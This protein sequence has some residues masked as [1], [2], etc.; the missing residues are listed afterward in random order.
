MSDKKLK[1]IS[2]MQESR[3]KTMKQKE[4]NIGTLLTTTKNNPTFAKLLIFTLN[5][6]EN[7]ISPPN[8]EIRVNA[9]VIIRL[10][11]VGIL[12]TTVI[13]N[14]SKDEIVSKAGGIIW[15]LISVYNNLD[16]E[17]AK[18]FAEKNGHKAVIEI[19][20]QRQKGPHEVTEP[21][22]KVL[23]GLVQIPQLVPSLLESGLVDTF[24][25]ESEENIEMI[26]LNLD[27]L[28][29]V[30][31]QKIGR[32][33]L[34][35]KNFVE[36]IIKNIKICTEKNSI[37]SVLC[38]LAVVDNLSRNED[39]KKAIKDSGGIDCLSEVLDAMGYDDYV[40]KMCAKIYG[41]IATLD[42]MQKQIILLKGYYET[43]KTGIFDNINLTDVKNCLVLI[44]NFML[45]DELGKQ[46]Q[47]LENFKLLEGTFEEIQKA[48]LEGKDINILKVYVLIN[49][50]FMQIFYRLFSL[51]INVYNKKTEAGKEEENLINTIQNSIKKTWEISK[52]LTEKDILEIFSTYFSSYGEIINQKYKIL[53][54]SQELDEEMSNILC[55]I[56]NNVIIDGQKNF[57]KEDIN[58]HKIA[59][60]ILKISDELSIHN[61][62]ETKKD[63]LVQSLSICL[64]YLENLFTES[65]NDEILCNSL[66]V[67]Y[68]LLNSNKEIFEKNIE[69][70]I[71]KICDFMNK[72]MEHRYPC[73]Q[74]MKLLDK[75]L[76][77]EFVTKYIKEKDPSK[78]PTHGID[79]VECIVNVLAY[80]ENINKDKKAERN[81]SSRVE[82]EIN[83]I[84]SKLMERL[85]Q[86]EE[87]LKK[88]IKE[89]CLSADSFEPNNI[90]NK[91]MVTNLEKLTKIMVGLMTVKKFYEEGANDILKSLTNLIQK[92]VKY[93][94]FYKIDKENKK[95][96]NYT[97]VLEESAQR[98]LFEL[99]LSLKI[100]DISQKELNFQIY[101][102]GLNI[103]F[104]FLSKSSNNNNI[105]Y[106]LNYFSKNSEFIL[107]EEARILSETKESIPEKETSTFTSLLRK[108]I[109][110]EEVIGN[111]INNL[112]LLGEKKQELCNTMVKGGCPRLLLQI[113]ETSPYEENVEK[114]LNLLKIIA[115]CNLNNLTMVANQNAMIKFFEAKNKYHS[116][117]T[118]INNCDEIS[119]EILKQVPGQDV[120]ADELIKDA[121]VGFNENI[122]NDFTLAEIKQKLLNNLEIINSFSTNKTQ[123]ENLNK[124]T[125]FIS[126][127]KDA[128]NKIFGE[129]KMTQIIEKLFSNLLSL[130]KKLNSLDAFDHE[131]TTG[132]LIE[133]IKNKSNL[134]DILLSATEEIS[135][136]LMDE[137][138]YSKL[139]KGK[140]DN[141]F[142]DAIFEDIDDYL[143]D[144]NVSKELNNILCYLCLRDEQM[145][146]Y[147][148]EKGGLTNVLEEL[149][150]NIDSNDKNSKQMKINAIKM[151][152]SLCNDKE[153]KESLIKA[154]GLELLSKILENEAESYEDYK[155]N[156]YK[157]LFKT[158]NILKISEKETKE[159]ETPTDN[160]ILYCV[161]LIKNIIE[162]DNKDFG[163]AKNIKNLLTISEGEYPKKDVFIE[164]CKIY[165]SNEHLDLP[166]EDNYIFL[167]L[168]Q[169]LSF[170]A[171]LGNNKDINA[172]DK[173]AEKI[174]S[175][176]KEN[177][178]FYDKIKIS[179]KENKN[180]TL[181]LTYLGN[182]VTLNNTF[183]E[184]GKNFIDEINAF[185]N[186]LLNLYKEKSTKE[187]KEE[188]PEGIIITILNL[189][190][191]ALTTKKESAPKIGDF[192]ETLLYLGEPYINNQEKKLFTLLYEDK[193]NKIFELIGKTKEDK[194]FIPEYQK[195]IEKMG[196]KSIPVLNITHE[197][198]NQNKD[199]NQMDKDIES[200]YDININNLKDFYTIPQQENT[201]IK[202]Q[203]MINTIN[204]L[205][206][207]FHNLENYEQN[208]LNA[209]LN[210]LYSILESI[211][212]SD[213]NKEIFVNNDETF[214][215]I[216]SLMK[217][218][219]EKGYPN[220]LS[221]F[222][223]IFNILAHNLENASEIYE[224]IT[225][226]IADDF[227]QTPQKEIDLN[228]N[229]LAEQ[230][231]NASAVKYLLN[232]KELE[233]AIHELYKDD[234]IDVQRRRDLSNIINNLTKNTYN[235]DN[236][237]QE[238]PEL[239]KTIMEKVSKSENVIKDKENVDIANNELNI[240][241]SIIK[242]ESNLAQIQSKN[243]ISKENIE[244]SIKMY[245]EAGN[246]EL[247]EN[248]KDI[249]QVVE[250]METKEKEPEQ[251][252]ENAPSFS[253]DSAIL[254]NIKSRIEE[255]FN[256]HLAELK[257]SNPQFETEDTEESEN[258]ENENIIESS[259]R[260]TKKNLGLIATHLYYNKYNSQIV[261]PLSTK[262]RDD[263]SNSLDSLLALIRLLYSGQ[264]N[265]PDQKVQEE[266][267]NLLNEC[268][269]V[270]KMLSICP[271]N[272]RPIIEFGLLN[273]L[274]KIYSEKKEE[275]FKL[276]MG[277]LDVLKNCTLTDAISIM[278]IDSSIFGILL[279]EFIDFY[280]NAD[281]LKQ[282][283]DIPNY[284]FL[285]NALFSNILKTQKGY[286]AFFNKVPIDKLI[287]IGK[288]TGNLDLLINI[289]KMLIDYL[290][291]KKEKL[292]DEQILNVLPICNKGLTSPER[293]EELLSQSFTLTGLIYNENTKEKIGEM[294]LVQIVNDTFDDGKENRVYFKNAMFV[295]GTICLDNKTYAEEVLNTKLL[296]KMMKEININ[297]LDVK[298][299]TVEDDDEMVAYS[300]LLKNL[301]DKKEENRK[302]MCYEELFENILK[303]IRIYTPLILQ[304]RKLENIIVSDAKNSKPRLFNVI[305]VSL[306]KVLTLLTIEEDSKDIISKIKFIGTI[307]ETINK[308]NIFSKIVI[309][310]L[311]ALRNY[312]SKVSPEKWNQ[313]E[314]EDLYNIFKS[315]QKDFYANSEILTNINHICGYIL[316]GCTNKQLSEKYYLLCLE[317][318]NCQD[319]NLDLVF[320][321]LKIIKENLITHEDLRNDIFEQTKQS[322]LNILRIYLN[323]LEIQT[324]CFEILSVFAENKV[325]SFNIVNSDIMESIRDALSNPD[326]NSDKDKRMQIRI[327]VFKLLNYLAYDDS[328]SGKISSELM[329]PFINDLS[330]K[331]FSDDLIQISSL[332]STLLRT[333][334][335][336]D[337]FLDN[338]G[339]QALCS[340]IENFYEHRKFILNCFKMIKEICFSS[341]ENKKKLKECGI[342]EKIKIAMDNCKPEDKIIK[343]EGKIAIKNIAYD[344]NEIE[345]KPFVPPNYQEIKSAKL[346][347]GPLYD[348]LTKGITVKGLNNPKA[349]V[350][351]F[352]LSFSPDL[353]KISFHKPKTPLAPPKS[354]YTLETPLCKIV[355]G[356]STDL[357]KKAG[358]IFGKSQNKAFCFSI[359]ME[360][361][362]GEK[363]EKTLNVICTNE[364]DLDKIFGAFEIGIYFAKVKCG[365]AERGALNE[366]NSYLASIA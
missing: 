54:E 21:F 152:S 249:E 309:Q 89:F 197:Q 20:V 316:K 363:K 109:E 331:A 336:I 97:K 106:I 353:M 121:I 273:F 221:I 340:A 81:I 232:N 102:Q 228:L 27:T 70:I 349:K 87:D 179:L 187:E 333:P 350:K 58:S 366:Q 341:E 204:D 64:P 112:T 237:I 335:S 41:K 38:G 45:V 110:E 356:R 77:P 359:I 220:D 37:D 10:E 177:Q 346:I 111:I 279:N 66:E 319:W 148:K 3:L 245:K 42:D 231:K 15:K 303:I 292:T 118:I 276:L 130:L 103:L 318:L 135:N 46:L 240:I 156:D 259:S 82:E 277:C 233:K 262:I 343:F 247:T 257:K 69:T 355:K 218:S 133:I 161:Q 266:R 147:I 223:H 362:D 52:K 67:I 142:I 330:G 19:L 339:N 137:E 105:N 144:I 195:Y 290:K 116:N 210:I 171:I 74:C 222:E 322:V 114:A 285:E 241:N 348:Y 140:L 40:L 131:Y 93:I 320:L 8:R 91:E 334:Q 120:N 80:T 108:I 217:T 92:E 153:G 53:K 7:Y 150:T 315:L 272:H 12:H 13:K 90:K 14:I 113:M 344:K 79:F 251:K 254:T 72:K 125:D 62:Q 201:L 159:E 165:N 78:Y 117:Q 207:D 68:D 305:L 99:S 158:R 141:S 321:S 258:P 56:N 35:T 178:T 304:K 155:P 71:F 226:F 22:V 200:L 317:G 128:L 338:K 325:L 170:K 300:D 160:Y 162:P 261:S 255:S 192:W 73:L 278:L 199:Y 57:K 138:L 172:A 215:K 323:S 326:F 185:L 225:E 88:I 246:E 18:L 9:S 364:K 239:I 283:E 354:K 63:E 250:K 227:K 243:L 365:K 230:T 146:S 36:K 264:K 83:E 236:I 94:E 296:D 49:K 288:N 298:E 11:G 193:L 186:D 164:L 295:L 176:I 124:E 275:N 127:L 202:P 294:N 2:K 96:P 311:L 190:N 123:F 55:F 30:S 302:K 256:N 76:S 32:D 260:M 167:F 352:V 282:N 115:F 149:K 314:I 234:N 189:Y 175:N 139:L 166:Q 132:K 213:K 287:F 143:G 351:E 268:I 28:K 31:N 173:I 332:L 198:L 26:T 265:N 95:K 182:Y 301:L 51:Q 342:E 119:N 5:T 205:I 361:M 291:V 324:L 174:L 289:M 270:L 25:L 157:N 299:P 329:E 100:V 216:L 284:F 154:N 242:D 47:N 281:K 238:D 312:F 280:E 163:N 206:T 85:F 33:F 104:L 4:E 244:S 194:S 168:K 59:S 29:K 34:I 360:K 122:K 274:E 61:E 267:T 196:P 50:Y 129:E 358:G 181:Q 48:D 188:I 184:S 16:S 337:L 347:K 211:S 23:N 224:K 6:L 306:F 107:S 24:N 17:L 212:K 75:Y 60:N 269:Y 253:V 169:I 293:T 101:V 307:S 98:L 39:G 345:K 235:V 286:E 214:S 136:Y 229:T 183:A 191:Y 297:L 263:I 308:P 219:K 151:L 84:G 145:A 209:Q 252:K 271:D 1:S 208:K 328:T 327:C 134:R 86:E 65:D 248:I 180:D 310:A 313:N 44:S 43:I 203:E 126:N 357:F